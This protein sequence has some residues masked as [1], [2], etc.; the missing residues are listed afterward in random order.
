MCSWRL[1]ILFAALAIPRETFLR[2]VLRGVLRVYMRGYHGLELEHG[3]R[4]PPY[5]GLLIV[6]NH[7]SLL[8]VPALMVL[9]PYPDTTTIVKASLFKV[10][11]LKLLLSEWGAI[12]VE[13]QGRDLGSV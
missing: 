3:E 2:R 13:R 6:L 12:P 8:D 9:D 1:S 7:A 4:L 11:G 5:G 10:P